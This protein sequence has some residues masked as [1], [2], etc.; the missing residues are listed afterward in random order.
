MKRSTEDMFVHIALRN[1]IR[2]G[3]LDP[4]GK[5]QEAFARDV[6]RYFR[7]LAKQESF[8]ISI[9]HRPTLLAT[10]RATLSDGKNEIACL[11][12]AT[13]LEHW[14]NGA[15]QTLLQ[16]EGQPDNVIVQI[17]R[18]CQ[19]RAKLT[20]V[21]ALLGAPPIAEPHAKAMVALSESRNWFV[22]Y[23]WNSHNPDEGDPQEVKLGEQLKQFEKTIGYLHRYSSRNLSESPR[24]RI[25]TRKPPSPQRRVAG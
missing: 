5:S 21:L 15:I 7:R 25:P 23:K 1:G 6:K 17:V 13:W 3:H 8:P 22:H 16:R 11:L 12:L 4:T 10:A 19:F 20:W 18:D 2:L 9:D 24:R 14:I